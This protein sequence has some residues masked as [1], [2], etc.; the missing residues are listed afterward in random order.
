MMTDEAPE[1]EC[2]E[3]EGNG[4]VAKRLPRL[5]GGVYEVNCEH[6][7]GYGWRNMTADELA[8]RA[9]RQD[10]VSHDVKQA[11]AAEKGE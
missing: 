4:W 1:I 11:F 7:S 2:P 8:D 3:C 5:G 6:C 10:P 9:E